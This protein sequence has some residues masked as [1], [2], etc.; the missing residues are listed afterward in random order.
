MEA[1]KVWMRSAL[2]GSDTAAVNTIDV[3]P[4][5]IQYGKS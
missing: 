4:S 3:D 1:L 5:K 2:V